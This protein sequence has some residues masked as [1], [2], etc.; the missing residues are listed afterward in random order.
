M[1]PTNDDLWFLASR[2]TLRRLSQDGPDGVSII[3]HRSPYGDSPP[4]HLHHDEDEVFHVIEGRLRLRVGNEELTAGPGDT[5]VAPKG[6]PHTYRVESPEGA[7]Y[8]TLVT[9]AGF[10]SMVRA[11]S[12]PAAAPGLP[13][14]AMPTPADVERLARIAASH[15]IDIV[16]PPLAA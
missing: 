9:G 6:L 1:H 7:R 10:E 14:P 11:V 12:R 13:P 8:L 16:G 2:V 4:T 3:E 5:V 15:A